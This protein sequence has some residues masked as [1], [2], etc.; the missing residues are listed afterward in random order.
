MEYVEGQ[1]LSEL[2]K[3]DGPLPV[4]Q[5]LAY[6]TEAARGLAFAHAA[7]VVHRDVKPANLLV[8]A[9]GVVKVLDMGLARLPLYGKDAGNGGLTSSGVVMGTA[10]FMAPE[11]AADTHRADERSD[12]Y[13]LGCCLY[14]LLT[15]WP[16]YE[17]RTPMEILF[18]HREQP[19]PSLRKARPDCPPRV[20]ALF[21]AM[22]AKRPE[23]RPASMTAVHS[24]L[25]SLQSDALENAP[26][27]LHLPA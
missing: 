18:A 26:R 25:E 17:G 2:V 9:G 24:E 4:E 1:N 12:V 10:A 22:I 16:P 11:Q 20:D 14:F 23:D 3:R 8:D 19:I 27:R 6:L 7:G 21:R 15:G 13:S 5:A